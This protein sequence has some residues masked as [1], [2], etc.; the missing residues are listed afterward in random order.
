M[1]GGEGACVEVWWER[2]RER[3][4]VEYSGERETESCGDCGAVSLGGIL[5]V[6][7]LLGPMLFGEAG[8]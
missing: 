4:G 8:S 1:E 6:G 5:V 3:R 7:L 2:R